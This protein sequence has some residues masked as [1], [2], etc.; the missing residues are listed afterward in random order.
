MKVTLSSRGKLWSRVAEW[1][2]LNDSFTVN[3]YAPSAVDTTKKLL[4]D[5]LYTLNYGPVVYEYT[6]P[7]VA[8]A[9]AYEMCKV[10]A[11]CYALDVGSEDYVTE[12][13]IVRPSPT[14]VRYQWKFTVDTK[15]A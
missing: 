12:D 1:A 9:V 15:A 4:L 7:Q 5:R 11:G 10:T 13:G 3:D 6:S 8:K 2:A 14:L